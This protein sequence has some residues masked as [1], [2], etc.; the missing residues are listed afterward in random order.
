MQNL[1]EGELAQAIVEFDRLWPNLIAESLRLSYSFSS[2]EDQ[3]N[4]LSKRHHLTTGIVSEENTTA[5]EDATA[6]A[7]NES[8]YRTKNKVDIIGRG[9]V[10]TSGDD[11]IFDDPADLFAPATEE[12]KDSTDDKCCLF[13]WC[14]FSFS[15]SS[16]E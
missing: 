8:D 3:R 16:V 15:R 6:T 4:S 7:E 9:A 13:G 12:D 11:L 10:T 1:K 5:K 2:T 14:L